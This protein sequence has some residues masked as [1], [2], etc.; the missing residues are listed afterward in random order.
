MNENNEMTVTRNGET[1]QLLR[2]ERP[3]R[4]DNSP[5]AYYTLSLVDETKLKEASPEGKT[6][7]VYDEAVMKF[8]AA[9]GAAKAIDIL[10]V[11]VN[12]KM[13]QA[14][15]ESGKDTLS[16]DQKAQVAVVFA[17][18]GNLGE[19][20]AG[21]I[22]AKDAEIAKLQ[23]QATQ[24]KELMNRLASAQLSEHAAIFAEIAKITAG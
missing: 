10:Q 19:V 16:M 9:Y 3:A 20:R 11:S 18:E 15:L 1:Y 21:K 2:T 5:V 24:M 7:L 23:R 8:L 13:C 12:T 4:G 17:G 22:A 14:Q 6:D